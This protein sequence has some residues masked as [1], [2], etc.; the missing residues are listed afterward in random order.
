LEDKYFFIGFKRL[1]Y[2]MTH[3]A[4]L[5]KEE[6]KDGKSEEAGPGKPI[7]SPDPPLILTLLR[8]LRA[9]PPV[10]LRRGRPGMP[11]LGGA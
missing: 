2:G 7:S 5:V 3:S 10:S 4:D 9:R 6:F 1:K 8:I 11:P